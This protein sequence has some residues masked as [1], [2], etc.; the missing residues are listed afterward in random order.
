MICP[1]KSTTEKSIGKSA[2][3]TGLITAAVT[4]PYQTDRW[5]GTMCC[6]SDFKYITAIRDVL[7][8]LISIYKNSPPTRKNSPVFFS[9]LA[10]PRSIIMT[11]LKRMRDAIL[12]KN[13]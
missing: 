8:G 1:G 10:M 6:R 11:G 12:A 9:N 3:G 5:P 7:R 13:A 4:D 2:C